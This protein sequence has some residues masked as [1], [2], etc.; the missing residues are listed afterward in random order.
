MR[1]NYKNLERNY[2]CSYC[3][4]AVANLTRLVHHT[5]RCIKGPGG[6][7][8]F[9]EFYVQYYKYKKE[10]FIKDY[11]IFKKGLMTI[12]AEKNIPFK[13][14]DFL[15]IYYK[16]KRTKKESSIIS[17]QNT[18]NT[19]KN[20]YSVDNP[21][22]IPNVRISIDN[23]K[24]Y[25]KSSIS[26]KQVWSDKIYRKNTIIKI[27]K[28]LQDRYGVDNIFSLKEYQD[29]AKESIINR[30]GVDN[31]SKS[32]YKR[33]ILASR[34]LRTLLEDVGYKAY[35][36]RVRQLT[37]K[38]IISVLESWKAYN[39]ICYYT[40]E[41][42]LNVDG[43]HLSDRLMYPTIDHKVSVLFGYLND[44][45]VEIISSLK[46]LCVCS[47]KINSIKSQ[48]TEEEFY[49]KKPKN[50]TFLKDLFK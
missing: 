30:F 42:L 28:S 25:A 2:Y 10:D 29:K 15:A 34:K 18:K 35:K 37:K 41:Q 16:I 5:V 1:K 24:R 19:I 9:E 14:L 6:D 3:S 32:E 12:S 11:T 50:I 22:D 39:P 23:K 31:I 8:A 46:N 48:L 4:K 49:I 27:K 20:R 13:V 7:K 26:M 43:S 36:N 33:N 44:I 40:G 38:H 21:L 45:P 17:I 47:R